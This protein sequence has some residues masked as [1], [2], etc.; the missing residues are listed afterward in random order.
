MD[1]ATLIAIA[2][3]VVFLVWLF[4]GFPVGFA[5]AGAG[6]LFAVLG[7]GLAWAGFP[8]LDVDVGYINLTVA[9]VF[10]IM[11][12]FS[13]VAVPMFIYMG[14]ILDKS[15]VGEELLAITN[16]LLRRVPGGLAVAVI[17]VGTILAASTGVAAA[18][19][20]MLG[21]IAI[22]AMLR[23][24]YD[25]GLAAGT[26]CVAG[27]LGSIIPPSIMLV[28]MADQMGVSVGDLF[29]GA[30]VP[31]IVLSVLYMS[32]VVVTGLLRPSLVPTEH[33]SGQTARVSAGEIVR[34]LAAPVLLM[35]VVLGSIFAGI[36]SPTEAGGMGAFGALLVT[37]LNGRLS[38]ST[39]VAAALQA[40]RTT[41]VIFVILIGATCF[42]VVLRGL[43]GDEVIQSALLSVSSSPETVV[44]VILSMI[45]LLGF[46]LDWIEI[47][48]I[49]LP[50]S[51][52]I[53]VGLGID[54]VWFTI[55]V[56]LTLQT[57]FIT[58]PVGFSLFY[59]RS[60]MP[61]EITTSQLYGGIIPFVALQL[62]CTA[63]VYLQPQLVTYLPKVV[64]GY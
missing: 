37:L 20:I 24:R 56:A 45:F 23:N 39:F 61:P 35:L 36:A 48:L 4:A 40:A 52:P 34:G 11:S 54:P 1:S 28:I 19:I 8:V 50:L 51:L 21:T 43:G 3:A 33:R 14:A 38:I 29:V 26:I 60:V 30:L 31:G 12:N 53:I 64:Y 58:P 16:K 42:A 46:L 5:L 27:G 7:T 17:A 41:S 55:L 25:G 18:S 32:F 62:A 47:S 57:S 44:L 10:A 13:L 59:V 22:P 15:G 9:R 6:T 63:A 49:L 2:Y